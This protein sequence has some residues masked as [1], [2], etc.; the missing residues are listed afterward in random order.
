MTWLS[1]WEN[2]LKLTISGGCIEDNLY[3]FPVLV[4]I[5][6]SYCEL[7]ETIG[8]NSKKIQFTDSTSSQMY[9]TE[10]QHWDHSGESAILWTKFDVLLSGGDV[11]FFL[12]YDNTQADN[13]TYV[14]NTGTSAAQTIWNSNFIGVYHFQE[15]SGALID[16]TS[17]GNHGV[18]SN[19][20]T[21]DRSFLSPIGN[22]TVFDNENKYITLPDGSDFKPNLITLE[23][24]CKT[25]ASNL[26]YTRILDRSHAPN[27]GYA[28]AIDSYGRGQLDITIPGPINYKTETFDIVEGNSQWNNLAGSYESNG[29]VQMYNNGELNERIFGAA[30][31]LTHESTQDPI[32]GNGVYDNNYRG[33][34]CELRISS[35][36]RSGA[37]IKASNYSNKNQLLTY[38][39]D[40]VKT[41]EDTFS[42]SI[43]GYTKQ[44]GSL[45]SR[46]V[47]LYHQESGNLKEEI[48]SDPVTGEFSFNILENRLDYYFLV[49]LDE[50]LD[51]S[52][53]NALVQDKIIPNAT[54][55]GT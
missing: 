4:K 7:F 23:A 22:A 53:F 39:I 35:N 42:Y 12:Y 48:Q 8:N 3:N 46:K 47:R 45:V 24:Y 14:G 21:E 2:R 30:A 27:Y 20:S 38:H 41:I 32:I 40:G 43:S 1:G 10:I 29:L 37:W 6:S 17:N 44:D 52:N 25:Y 28:L 34:I 33:E 55:S 13:D 36:G 19:L 9:Y 5:D 50:D 51:F 31:N 11:D 49:I 16:S 15:T 26:D 18:V 54:I